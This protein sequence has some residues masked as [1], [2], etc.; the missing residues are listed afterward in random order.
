VVPK[1]CIFYK[2]LA[3]RAS[4]RMGFWF[5]CLHDGRPDLMYS[6]CS[7]LGSISALC[8]IHCVYCYFNIISGAAKLYCENKSTINE[9]F[10]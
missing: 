10:K 9:A 7:E 4:C 1:S 8:I 2:L 3:I 5:S 6:N